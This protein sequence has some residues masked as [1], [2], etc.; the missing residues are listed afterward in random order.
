VIKALEASARGVAVRERVA[1]IGHAL[2]EGMEIARPKPLIIRRHNGEA[3]PDEALKQRRNA[4][5]IV[6]LRPTGSIA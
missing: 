6:V 1:R 2:Q 5:D 4:A 3:R